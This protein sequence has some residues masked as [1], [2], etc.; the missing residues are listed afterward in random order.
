[1]GAAMA[2]AAVDTLVRYF[3]HSGMKPSDFDL[4]A[5]GDLGFEGRSIVCDLMR[6]RGYD[7]GTVYD[8]C[9]LMI[10]DRERQ[11]MH[12]GGSGCGCST[13]I[14]SA[15]LLKALNDG[16]LRDILWI[17]TGALM[18]P[19]MLQQGK[20]IPGIAHLLRITKENML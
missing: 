14:L 13:T 12:A 7:L 2:P 15:K 9:G 10:Y 19:M 16:T 11:D 8:D 20:S 4:I 5:T 17:G 6:Q 18:S 3:K 1:M